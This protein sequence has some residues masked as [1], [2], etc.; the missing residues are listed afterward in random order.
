MR[1]VPLEHVE[2][3]GL[4]EP[5]D[6]VGAD[7]RL[8]L[9]CDLASLAE[10]RLNDATDPRALTDAR[11]DAWQQKATLEGPSPIAER[12]E[13]GRCYWLLEGSE[14]V[15]TVALSRVRYGVA[16]TRVSSLYVFP[17]RRRTGVGR[18]A[19]ARLAAALGEKGF[20]YQL[21]TCWAWQPAVRFYLRAGHWVLTWKRDLTFTAAEGLPKP[22]I[23][24]SDDA[25]TLSA[26]ARGRRVL[27]ATAR[28]RGDRLTLDDAP[29]S[30]QAG[31][32]FAAVARLAES[33]LALALALEGRPLVRSR[34]AW[35]D[36]RDA[37]GGPPE[38]LA[39]KI[40]AWEAFDRAQGWCVET[41]RIPGLAYPSWAEFEANWEAAN[42]ATLVPQPRKKK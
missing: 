42:A 39:Q 28:T 38:A 13:Y 11:R 20:G 25:I 9:D 2:Q 37:D 18:R 27:L 8:W 23:E 1:E 31:G 17:S 10:H 14:R 32:P 4:V 35:A 21:D 19:L 26:E 40:T 34:R 3:S 12:N 6:L 5:V 33:T 36:N 30:T 15:G 16:D 41:P 7:A 24:V 29:L 22:L